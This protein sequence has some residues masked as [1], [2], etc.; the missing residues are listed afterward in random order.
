MLQSNPFDS[1]TRRSRLQPISVVSY[2]Q[3]PVGSRDQL[4]ETSTSLP[5]K[6]ISPKFLSQAKKKLHDVGGFHPLKTNH[7]RK[8]RSDFRLTK[9]SSSEGFSFR[10]KKLFQTSGNFR[11]Q[12]FFFPGSLKIRRSFFRNHF[13][14]HVKNIS[15]QLDDLDRLGLF[16]SQ[17][18]WGGW[19]HCNQSVVSF[20]EASCCVYKHSEMPAKL[21]SLDFRSIGEKPRSIFHHPCVM[22]QAFTASYVWWKLKGLEWSLPSSVDFCGSQELF[23]ANSGTRLPGWKGVP[24]EYQGAVE[25]VS[26]WSSGWE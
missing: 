14:W 1:P 10:R 8:G 24:V 25:E 11:W 19:F 22:L 7:L 9:T 12:P 3:H 20:S 26:R 21:A 4:K 6:K 18:V 23:C 16:F 13:F 2:F 17:R 5:P 15:I